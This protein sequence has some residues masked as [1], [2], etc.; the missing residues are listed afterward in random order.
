MSTANDKGKLE[1]PID[2]D[3]SLD[4][5]E[6]VPGFGVFPTGAY[7][8]DFVKGIEQKEINDKKAASC[9]MTLVEIG[10]LKEDNLDEGEKPPMPGDICTL[11][12]MLD[13]K[14]GADGLKK[15]CT[16][17][18]DKLGTKKLSEIFHQSKGL[19]CL[20][21]VRRTYNEKKDQ[22]YAKLKKLAVV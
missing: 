21:V 7:L 5:I 16:P 22:H 1:K 13:N 3:M 19:R 17:L 9:E 10:E 4:D 18:A 8:V 12:W 14:F 15:F 6:D 2:L 20:I 11:S